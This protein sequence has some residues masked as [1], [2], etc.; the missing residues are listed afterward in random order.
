MFI[1]LDSSKNFC[2]D[3]MM[4][5]VKLLSHIKTFITAG[6]IEESIMKLQINHFNKKG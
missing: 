2:L 4:E 1:Y 5:L 6:K 3:C